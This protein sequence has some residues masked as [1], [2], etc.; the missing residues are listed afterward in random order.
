ML[1][2][3]EIHLVLELLAPSDTADRLNEQ[4]GVL[5]LAL[6]QRPQLFEQLR[7]ILRLLLGLGQLLV[8]NLLAIFEELVQV[9]VLLLQRL[10]LVHHL[11]CTS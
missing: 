3:L 7:Q 6:D 11:H 4:T 2:N 5:Y 9:L 1:V 10:Q 8:E